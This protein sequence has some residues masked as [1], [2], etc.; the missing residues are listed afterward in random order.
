MA[1]T[2][3]TGT[4]IGSVD[5]LT[6]TTIFLGGSGSA[7]ALDDYE[8][9]TWTPTLLRTT[10]NPTFSSIGNTTGYYVKIG[11]MVHV[12]YY[13]PVIAFTNGG[14][15]TSQIGGLPFTAANGT[16]EYWLFQYLHGDAIV[17]TTTGGY[18]NKN[19][20]VMTFVVQGSTGGAAWQS[21]GSRYLM[22][23]ASYRA[24]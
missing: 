1:L 20:N 8:E 15:G 12:T 13:A 18:I 23:S 3:I 2:Q 6:P 5:S 10:S 17:Q 16:E 7:N 24:A 11:N 9:G 4:G 21:S 19:G 14:S 22:V